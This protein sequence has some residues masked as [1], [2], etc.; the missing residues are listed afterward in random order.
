VDKSQLRDE[1]KKYVCKYGMG[2]S[3]SD[4]DSGL[5]ESGV[6]PKLGINTVKKK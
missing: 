1:K 6:K 4:E 2:I 5:S 3:V